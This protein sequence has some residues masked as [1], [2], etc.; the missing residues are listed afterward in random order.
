MDVQ[1]MERG[2]VFSTA[3]Q[4]VRIGGVGNTVRCGVGLRKGGE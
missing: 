2:R 3:A 1:R 4:K